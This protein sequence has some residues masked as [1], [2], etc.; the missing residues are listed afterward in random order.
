MSFIQTGT[1]T[2]ALANVDEAFAL[3]VRDPGGPNPFFINSITGTLIA[4]TNGDVF[5]MRLDPSAPAPA[6]I[7][8]ITC[9]YRTITAFTTPATFRQMRLRRFAGAVASGGT[10][11]ATAAQKDPSGASSEFNS[12]NGGDI[13]I[14]ATG[15]LTS[16]GTPDTLE[17]GRRINLTKYGLATDSFDWEWV[18]SPASGRSPL[19]LS[20]GMSVAIGTAAAFDAG[21]TWE[22]GV[23]VE[24]FEGRR[25]G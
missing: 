23:H 19:I 16:P 5:A 15:N 1:S 18:F 22:L 25:Q 13:R 24:Y 11:I 2:T 6:H 10:A 7:T 8:S 20:A 14:S 4:T 17:A 12:A 21:G 9:W 3:R